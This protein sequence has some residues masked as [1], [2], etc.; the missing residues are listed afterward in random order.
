[1]TTTVITSAILS[2]IARRQILPQRDCGELDSR[3]KFGLGWSP[4]CRRWLSYAEVAWVFADKARIAPALPRRCSPLRC[5]SCCLPHGLGGTGNANHDSTIT[6]VVA[7]RR[8][9][10]PG[11]RRRTPLGSQVRETWLSLS[12]DSADFGLVR[13]AFRFT[14]VFSNS[15]PAIG[16]R[17]NP[18]CCASP[19]SDLRPRWQRL[20]FL[21]F[22]PKTVPLSVTARRRP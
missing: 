20:H 22:A 9:E 7:G 6:L 4:R 14:A 8:Q 5:G 11:T 21:E 10:G 3:A 18:I 12:I 15:C 1:V 17:S 13:L 19:C 16:S 2:P